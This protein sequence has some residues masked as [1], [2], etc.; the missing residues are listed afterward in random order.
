MLLM[1]I[2]I[3]LATLLALFAI[4]EVIGLL[5][6]KAT[7]YYVGEDGKMRAFGGVLFHVP[8]NSYQFRDNTQPRINRYQGYSNVENGLAMINLRNDP[9]VSDLAAETHAEGWVNLSGE[10]FNK[11]GLRIGYITDAKGRPSIYGS[12]KWYELWLRKHSYV[13]TCPPLASEGGSSDVAGD[14]LVGRIV[15][16]GR[17]GR[18]RH[19]TYTVTARAGGFLLLYKDRQPRAESEDAVTPGATWKDTALLSALVFTLIY[20]FF[21]LAGSGKMALPAMKEQVSFTASMLLVFGILWALLRQVK[22]ES[23]LDGR[24]FGDFLM[25]MNRNTGVMALNN[26]IILGTAA[27]LLVSIFFF[28]SDFIPLQVAILIGV[29]VNKRYITHEPWQ[30]MDTEE[31]GSD[32]PWDGEDADGGLDPSV[33]D[34]A[35]DRSFSWQLDSPFHHL[36]GQFSIRFSREKIANLRKENPFRQNPGA[37][38]KS[39]VAALFDLCKDNVN[40]HRVL[41]YV[42]KSIREAGLSEPEQMQFI[43]D[44]VQSPN[45]SYKEDDKCEEIGNPREYARFPDE[46]MYDGR[47]DC[48]CKAVLAA[49][50]FKEAG[51]KTAYLTTATH[52]AVA[53][54]FKQAG[55]S[56]MKNLGGDSLLTH[57]GYMYFFCETTGDGFRIGDLGGTTRESLQ[58]IIFL[59]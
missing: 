55:S 20:F 23:E 9:S 11:D 56:A 54:A 27:S 39:N 15:E 45:I 47:G 42:S 52:A 18:G 13:Y 31:D 19:N 51:F 30:V 49:M 8:S 28:G 2:V 58:E 38:F 7:T 4:Y 50:L 46:T 16:T 24:R 6:K 14:I 43:L 5:R 36:E 34:D 21:Y 22:I 40:V 57:D 3:L 29:G 17:L 44:F 59:N 48:D 10:I 41:R 35:V 53:V 12:G 33:P 26:W 1:R 32:L 37:S 25:L